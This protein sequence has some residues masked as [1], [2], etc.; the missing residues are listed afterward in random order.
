MNGKLLLDTNIMIAIFAGDAEVKTS[1]AGAN[2]IFVPSIALGELYYGAH[3]SSRVEANIVRINEFAASSSVLTC[4]TETSQEYGRLKNSL[5]IK[6]RP[7][8][9]NDIWI[10]AIAKQYEL[11]LVSRDEH[12]NEI[13]ELSVMAW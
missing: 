10:A 11:T 2:E 8:P 3:K 9:E 12:F 7:I 5:R 4:D 13:D 6:G 1:L